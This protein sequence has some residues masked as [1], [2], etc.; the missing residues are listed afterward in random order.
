PP[1]VRAGLV[2]RTSR[3]SRTFQPRCASAPHRFHKARPVLV[4]ANSARNRDRM[5]P[6]PRRPDAFRTPKL[7]CLQPVIEEC[8]GPRQPSNPRPRREAEA[9]CVFVGERTDLTYFRDDLIPEKPLPAT[10]CAPIWALP[11]VARFFFRVQ[12]FS[13]WSC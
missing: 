11:D 13:A 7:R 12:D 8:P 4:T 9:V 10:G 3:T 2:Y 6:I 1:D 5:R